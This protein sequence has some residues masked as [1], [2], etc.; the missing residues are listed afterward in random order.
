MGYTYDLASRVI[1]ETLPDNRVINYSYDANGNV[2]SITPPGRP[3]HDFDYT[4]V[5][6][7]KDYMPPDIGT[8]TRDT[9]YN[10]DLDRRL[11]SVTRPVGAALPSFDDQKMSYAYDGSLLTST[12]WEGPVNGTVEFTYDNDFR[13]SSNS[14]IPASPESFPSSV[15]FIYDDDGLL[16]GAGDLSIN[17]D[18]DNGLLLGTTL[19]NVTDSWTYNGFGESESY[20][21]TYSGSPILTIQYTRD[22]LGRITHKTETVDGVT[23]VYGYFYDIAGRL[24]DVE[25]DGLPLSHYDYDLNGNRL[26]HNGI[27][28]T[29]DNQDRLVA[30]GNEVYTYTDN[31]ELAGKTGPSGTT[32]YGY[33]AFGNLVTVILPDDSVIEY[34]IDGENRRVGKKVDGVVVQGFLYEDQLRPVAE[35]DGDGNIV[36]RFV[37]GTQINVP[38]YMIKNGVTYRIITDHLGSPRVVVDAGTGV[39]V[40]RLDYDEFGNV[41]YDSNPGFQPFGFAG[42]IYDRHT[43]LVRFGARDYDAVTGKWTAK[44]PIGFVGGDANLFGYVGN[45]PVNFVDPEGLYSWDEFLQDS[46]NLSAGFAD[47]ITFC[48]TRWIREQ[49]GV[50]DVVNKCSDAYSGGKWAGY[51]WGVAVGGSAIGRALQIEINVLSRGNVLKII[52]KRLRSG[53]RIDPAHHG[54]K[55]GHRHYWRW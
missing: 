19:D 42:G 7:T 12:T 44:D 28:A 38:D 27:T 10:Y 49:M 46:A 33:D 47:T 55:W 2:T 15:N 8:A 1:Q 11:T 50:D 14:V 48:G 40:Q 13:I 54:K 53:F 29:Y 26:S 45:N 37:Y 52:S 4:P 25:K 39:V 18:P 43:N 3:A 17:R 24:T 20:S 5:D 35:L 16:T 34:V 51:A 21:A 30:Y 41:T 32:E 22:K 9:N 6:L 23:H 36:S 31:G